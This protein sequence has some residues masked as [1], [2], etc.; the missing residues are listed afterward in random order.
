MM[1]N[2]AHRI[3]LSAAGAALFVALSFCLQVPVWENYTLCLGYAV[4]A[5]WCWC[6]GPFAGTVTGVLGVILYCLLINGLRGMPGWALGNLVI[7]PVL[8]FTFRRTAGLRRPVLA[9]VINAL[10]VVFSVTAG[11][12]GVKSLTEHL[13][14]AQPF[15]VRAG[16][17]F[18]A[19]AADVFVLLVS[20]P[21]CAALDRI[22]NKRK[23]KTIHE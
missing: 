8:G 19:W 11:I 10:A 3:C 20:L 16:K 23:G 13:L 2:T 1:K 15:A 14:Y 7:G 22:W 4:M 21:L 6:F 18:A 9:T 5:V 17:N 12:L